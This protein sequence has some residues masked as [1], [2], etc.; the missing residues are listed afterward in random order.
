M[1]STDMCAMSVRHPFYISPRPDSAQEDHTVW[2]STCVD[3]PMLLTNRCSSPGTRKTSASSSSHGTSGP[4]RASS[5]PSSPLSSSAWATRPSA[6]ARADTR[7]SCGGELSPL[8]VS[9]RLASVVAVAAAAPPREQITP[10]LPP[11]P[12]TSASGQWS[13]VGHALGGFHTV[14]LFLARLNSP[15]PPCSRAN[16]QNAYIQPEVTSLLRRRRWRGR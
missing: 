10:F 4:P 11:P 15:Y 14:D 12:K 6:Q 9:P 13:T 2:G 16:L 5:S 7:L 1:P 8:P 3:D